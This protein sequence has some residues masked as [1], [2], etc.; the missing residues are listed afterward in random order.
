VPVYFLGEDENGCSPIK[1]GVAKNIEVR[2]R[3]LQTG[4]PLKLRLLGWIETPE[5]FQLEANL[6]RHFNAM[7]VRGEWFDI[8][9]ADILPFLQRVGRDGFVAKNAD[10][11]QITGY[12]R[13]A[14]P[15]HLGVWEWADLE[16]EECCPFCG[17]LGGMH[18]QEASQMYYCISCD[19]LTD[20]S[21][22]DPPDDEP[23]E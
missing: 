10:A 19:T 11:F 8:E 2:A 22:L 4:N 17:C 3:N 23:E 6:K 20:Y 9:P 21:E 18:F 15:E 13:D 5:V 14:V 7:R 1:I 12:D 16:M